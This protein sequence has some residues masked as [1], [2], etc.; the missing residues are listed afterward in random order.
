MNILITGGT[1]FVGRALVP[2]LEKQGHTVCILTRKKQENPKVAELIYPKEHELLNPQTLS[3]FQAVINLAGASISTTRWNK[4]GKE[5]IL[6]SRI[7]V[8][9]L[10]VDSMKQNSKLQLPYPKILISTSAV[11]FYGISQHEVFDETSENGAGFLA[12][13]AKQWE[14]EAR[15]IE[16][17]QVR[18]TILRFGIV[19]GRGGILTQ[20]K[21]PFDFK[22][23]GYVG[24]GK[25]WISW[26]ALDDL[27]R[28]ISF[29]VSNETVC[30]I[31]NA[32]TPNA[33]Q[34]KELIFT[35][36]KSLKRKAWTKLPGW[37]LKI[38]LGQMAEE[39]I[40]NGQKVSPTRLK[41]AGFL[42]EY[43]NITKAIQHIFQEI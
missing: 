37:V 38:F 13:V 28:M 27:L 40:L 9:K 32:C 34:M 22:V 30:G 6:D 7:T 14:E 42:Y 35:M 21:K 8:T 25:Q 26:I 1:G 24:S 11:G 20:L 12:E 33:V 23:G 15:K 3:D 5:L 4:K 2:F 19:L 16:V 10:L 18:C 17:L 29:A 31:Y 39:L 41:E 36:A 43:P